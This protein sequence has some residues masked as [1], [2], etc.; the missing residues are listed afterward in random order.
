MLN[1]ICVKVKASGLSP[2]IS[3]VSGAFPGIHFEM[4]LIHRVQPRP[5]YCCGWTKQ[6]RVPWGTNTWIREKA[7]GRVCRR[8]CVAPYLL[9]RVIKTKV[10]EHLPTRNCGSIWS[11]ISLAMDSLT[12]HF[13][14]PI[15]GSLLL[16]IPHSLTHRE[17]TEILQQLWHYWGKSFT[18]SYPACLPK[19]L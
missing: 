1:Q 3:H 19:Q 7:S 11:T 17:C 12:T 18:K 10:S 2:M 15:M 16:P 13:H 14:L 4:W 8:L 5:L 6:R 9:S